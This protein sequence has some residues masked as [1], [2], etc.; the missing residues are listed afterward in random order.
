MKPASQGGELHIELT[1]DDFL[2]R[3]K[4]RCLVAMPFRRKE[5]PDN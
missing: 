3:T 4:W 5:I 2:V 1:G